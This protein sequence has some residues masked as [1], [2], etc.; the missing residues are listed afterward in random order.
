[1]RIEW[2]MM[3]PEIITF[4]VTFLIVIL[5]FAAERKIC[6][7][8]ELPFLAA[9]VRYWQMLLLACHTEL[10]DRLRLG[11]YVLGVVVWIWGLKQLTK[12]GP[13]N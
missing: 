9:M 6:Q 3:P 10:F 7:N 4:L 12:A 5:L 1:M 8:L 11:T 13:I 2:G